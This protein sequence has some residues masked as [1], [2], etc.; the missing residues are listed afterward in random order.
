MKSTYISPEMEVVN[1]QA[2]QIL[3]SSSLSLGGNNSEGFTYDPDGFNDDD[4]R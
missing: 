4:L 2:N 3:C 1:I